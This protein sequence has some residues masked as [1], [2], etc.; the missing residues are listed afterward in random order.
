MSP[1]LRSQAL[2]PFI[3][4]AAFAFGALFVWIGV[5]AAAGG[6]PVHG[7]VIA[8][9]GGLGVALAFALWRFSRRP[10]ARGRDADHEQR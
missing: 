5:E 1:R 10:P 2:L 6:A 8:L 3:A 4:A 9:F 7:T